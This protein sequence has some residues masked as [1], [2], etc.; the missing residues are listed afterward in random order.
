MLRYHSKEE[1]DDFCLSS[2]PC[3]DKKEVSGPCLAIGLS[4]SQAGFLAG[5]KEALSLSGRVG[6]PYTGSHK[7][8]GSHVGC[9]LCL[10]CAIISEQR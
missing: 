2:A 3:E 4:Q 9:L 1:A 7:C 6:F 10:I 5:P 8:M